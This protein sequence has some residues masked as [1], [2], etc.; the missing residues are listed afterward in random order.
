M[1]EIYNLQDNAFIYDKGDS[2]DSILISE[3]YYY[4]TYKRNY[5][6]FFDK[7]KIARLTLM[8]LSA[9]LGNEKFSDL[10]RIHRSRVANKKHVKR[11]LPVMKGK[12]K[13]DLLM[14][15]LDR[16]GI[17]YTWLTHVRSAINELGSAKESSS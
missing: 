2:I 11:I 3:V 12:N 5:L 4:T 13:C 17:G 1:V 14:N 7:D 8:R 9:I 15:N 10:L 6:I 16:V